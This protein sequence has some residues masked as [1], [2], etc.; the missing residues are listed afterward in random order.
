MTCSHVLKAGV[1][2][3]TLHPRK[4]PQYVLYA[5][6]I[7]AFNPFNHHINVTKLMRVKERISRR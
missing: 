1:K 4:V 7:I 5:L 6:C 3:Q 2:P